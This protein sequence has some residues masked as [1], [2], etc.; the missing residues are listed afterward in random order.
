MYFFLFTELKKSTQS[1]SVINFL[2]I[3]AESLTIGQGTLSI[4]VPKYSR[5][6][7]TFSN[8]QVMLEDGTGKLLKDSN[9]LLAEGNGSKG[10]AD[11]SSRKRNSMHFSMQF[12]DFVRVLA[13]RY[14]TRLQT[15][16]NNMAL[17]FDYFLT[18]FRLF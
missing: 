2:S 18:Y 8:L 14:Q 3:E 11:V 15:N 17:D 9:L 4:N 6:M 16:F 10:P 13:Y 12:P 7:P 5:N 1:I